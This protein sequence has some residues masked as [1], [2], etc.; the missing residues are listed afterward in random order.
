VLGQN[1]SEDGAGVYGQASATTGSGGTGVLGTG[2][3]YGVWGAA[4][5]AN[6]IGVYGQCA[7]FSGA[8]VGVMG[9][10]NGPSGTG[11]TG[12]ADNGASSATGVF[13]RAI[14]G[15][16]VVGWVGA[17]GGLTTSAKSGVFGQC[18]I[19]TSSA[20]VFGKSI[21]GYAVRG[22]STTGIGVFGEASGPTGTALR[23]QGKA[24]FSRSGKATVQAGQSTV[25]VSGV[26]I[27]AA[28]LILAT[29]QGVGETGL[30]VKSVSLSVANSRF[31]IRLSKAVAGNTLV[32]WFIVN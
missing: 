27:T 16:G 2:P 11:V 12:R 24:V 20:G 1:A 21:A 26:T 15:I 25:L 30:Y 10:T 5:V 6:R 18:D 29:I 4:T 17:A 19:D 23:V 14:A 9:L 8:G 7:S 28:S 3:G 13:G 31:T 32:G 22:L